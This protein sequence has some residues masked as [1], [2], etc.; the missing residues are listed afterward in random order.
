MSYDFENDTPIY[1]QIIEKLKIKIINEEY[2]TNEKIP[3]V[4]ELS[5]IFE[6][7]PNTIQKSLN[8]LENIGLIVT[9]RTNGKYVTSDKDIINKA[10][11]DTINN[12]ILDFYKSMEEL[13]LTKSE[14]LKILNKE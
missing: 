9:D 4:R 14:I 10:K 5:V 7:N 12:K 8:E 13:G 3:S 2:K 11:K 6:V 1:L